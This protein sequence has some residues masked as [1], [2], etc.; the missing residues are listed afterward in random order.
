M[1]WEIVGLSTFITPPLQ[2]V[3]LTLSDPGFFEVPEPGGGVSPA[4]ISE[5]TEHIGMQLGELAENNKL[6]NL[7]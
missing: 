5:T 1:S 3:P 6:V 7:I 2:I 4:H